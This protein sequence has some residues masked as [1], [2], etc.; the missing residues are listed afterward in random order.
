MSRRII[1]EKAPAVKRLDTGSV[2]LVPSV[3][4]LIADALSVIE[5]EI[6]RFRAKSKQGRALELKEARVLQGYIKSLVELSK[7]ARE[8]AKGEDLSNLSDEELVNLVQA[9]IDKKK[10]HVKND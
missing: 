8:R 6:V 7:E 4:N 2:L 3:E 9:I 1:P 5:V 10:V